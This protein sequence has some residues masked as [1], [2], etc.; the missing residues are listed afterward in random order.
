MSSSWTETSDEDTHL[1]LN[2]SS[3]KMLIPSLPKYTSFSL[4]LQKYSS[5]FWYR[6]RAAV[7]NQENVWTNLYKPNSEQVATHWLVSLQISLP[8]CLSARLLAS[9]GGQ[10]GVIVTPGL[11]ITQG[12]SGYICT[13]IQLS[14]KKTIITPSLPVS[15]KTEQRLW[16]MNNNWKLWHTDIMK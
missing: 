10:Q 2:H 14:I 8:P 3:I 5:L 16:S 13:D 4:L 11:Q 15:W 7:R 1:S 9:D 6:R 12:Q